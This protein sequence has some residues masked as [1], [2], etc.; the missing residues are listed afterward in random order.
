M[1]ERDWLILLSLFEQKSITKTAEVLFI[2]QP[3]LTSRLQQI[4][5]RFGAQI[6]IRGKKGVCFTP[7]GKYLVECA[8]DMVQRMH[9]IEGT[10]QTI[11]NEARGSI[12]IG[13]SILF[14]R[15]KLPRLLQQ[16]IQLYPNAEF[17]LST[18]L[19]GKIVELMHDNDLDVGFVRGDYDW[20]DKKELL[21]EEKMFIVS[22]QKF[23]IQDLPRLLRVEHMSNKAARD[24]H[25]KWW[26][27]NFSQRPV[28]GMEV[29]KVDSCKE[30]V[31]NGLG[32]AFLPEGVLVD[33]DEIYKIP[34]LDKEGKG[35]V[36]RTWMIYREDNMKIGLVKTFVDF[37]NIW[38][39]EIVSEK[40]NAR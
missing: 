8:K 21:F 31:L 4:E 5:Q 32:Y 3:T 28:V 10:I 17:R 39:C 24:L 27:E 11:R 26:K 19:S 1:E 38:K 40:N 15:H 34:M 37:V 14:I 2:S 12:N 13:A 18:Q 30:I 29:D 16:F 7:E 35:L 33:A 22:K 9:A 36:R 23:A 20:N 25:D 6:V